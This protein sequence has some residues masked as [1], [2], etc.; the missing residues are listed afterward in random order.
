[1]KDIEQQGFGKLWCV[2]LPPPSSPLPLSD[3][4]LHTVLT[5]SQTVDWTFS[6]VRVR[7]VVYSQ[8]V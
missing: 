8:H 3:P 7:P 5:H 1:M 2:S 6:A 4:L